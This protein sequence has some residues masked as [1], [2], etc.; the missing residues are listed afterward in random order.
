[1]APY[2][3][4]CHFANHMRVPMQDCDGVLM[5]CTAFSQEVPGNHP[6]RL[7]AAVRVV[8]NAWRDD[9]GLAMLNELVTLMEQA[10]VPPAYTQHLSPQGHPGGDPNDSTSSASAQGHGAPVLT[11]H[12]HPSSES[13]DPTLS[14]STQGHVP[15]AVAQSMDSHGMSP[16]GVLTQ[17]LAPPAAVDAACLTPAAS[18]GEVASC[19]EDFPVPL[20]Q[21]PKEP[22]AVDCSPCSTGTVAMVRACSQ[23][24]S[25][26]V[27][28]QVENPTCLE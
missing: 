3:L 18:D 20:A 25:D 16:T 27:T 26:S 21:R 23:S 11:A 13:N 2:T 5:H 28:A 17:S 12:D 7:H 15:P 4:G 10:G 9:G 22:V 1:M 14:S 6:G 19:L 8:D 24:S